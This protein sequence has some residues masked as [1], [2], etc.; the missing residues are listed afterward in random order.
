MAILPTVSWLLIFTLFAL[1]LLFF[2]FTYLAFEMPK[3]FLLYIFSAFAAYILLISG[4]KLGKLSII[5]WV[6]LIFFAWIIITA[7]FGLSWQ[8]SFW[9]SYF[10]MQGIL[11]WICYFLLFFI[12]GKVFENHYFKKYACLAILIA[13]TVT[14]T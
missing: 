13:S 4:Y 14:A 2:P 8:Q 1:P 9:G 6:Y 11:T 5:Y 12:S 3:V 7:I 10:R